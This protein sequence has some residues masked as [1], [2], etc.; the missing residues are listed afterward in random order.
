MEAWVQETSSVLPRTGRCLLQ[1]G[2]PTSPQVL[3]RPHSSES[4]SLRGILINLLQGSHC[5]PEILFLL[6]VM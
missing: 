1:R 4:T 5:F 6:S 2:T 3:I